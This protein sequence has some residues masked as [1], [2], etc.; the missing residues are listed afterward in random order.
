[1]DNERAQLAFAYTPQATFSL[2]VNT[3]VSER[4]R[5]TQHLSSEAITKQKELSW[6]TYLGSAYDKDSHGG[7]SSENLS[8]NFLRNKNAQ[9]REETLHVGPEKIGQLLAKLPATSHPLSDASKFVVDA[10]QQPGTGEAYPD[11]LV[12]VVHGEFAE[13]RSPLTYHGSFTTV[14]LLTSCN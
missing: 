14:R 10:W 4:A 6:A 9:R 8:R 3:T 7:K 11:L 1:M 13:R 12:V 5:R 2:S